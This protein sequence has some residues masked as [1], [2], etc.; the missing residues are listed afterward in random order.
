MRIM[1]ALTGAK[2][3]T[4]PG[5]S[6]WPGPRTSPRTPGSAG[7]QGRGPRCSAA[8]CRGYDYSLDE[9]FEFGVGRLLDGL[10]SLID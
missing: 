2:P 1:N 3:F 5:G 8:T 9:L 4:P 10:A 7:T 6:C